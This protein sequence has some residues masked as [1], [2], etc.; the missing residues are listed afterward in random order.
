MTQ[1]RDSGIIVLFTRHPVAANL[2]MLMMILSGLWAVGRINT[3]L[4]PSVAFPGVFIDIR[5]PGAPAE[6]VEQLIVN[7]AEQQLSTLA[8]LQQMTSITREGGS[9]IRLELPFNSD[10]SAALD[11]V[12]DRLSQIRNFP[13]DMEPMVAR[14]AVDY[15]YIA[16]VLIVGGSSLAELV[17]LARRAERELYAAG[18]DRVDFTGLPEDELAIQVGSASLMAMHTTLD[19]LAAEIRQ[20]SA[21]VPAG[22]VAR[23][24]GGMQLRGMD[25]RRDLYQF[26]QLDIQIPGTGELTRLGNIAHIDRRAKVGQPQL[27]REGRPAIELNLRRATNSD[28]LISARI[29]QGWLATAHAQLPPGVEIEVYEEVGKLLSQQLSVIAKNASSGL[30]LVVF[31]LFLFLN[32]R[33]GWWVAVGIPVGLLFGMVFY[34]YLFNGSIN[35][36]ALITFIMAIGIVVDDT[37]VVGEDAVSLFEQGLSPEDAVS[38]AAQRMFMPVLTASLTTLAAFVPLLITGGEVGA[39]IQTMPMVLFCVIAASLVECFLVLP[40]HLKHSFNRM[41]R[42]HK[43]K[44]RAQVDRAFFGFRDRYYRPLLELALARPGAT[45]LTA[46][47]LTVLS[48][49]L[50]LSGRVG[51]NFVTGMSLQMLEANVAFT[52]DAP[53][54]ERERYMRHLELTLRDTDQQLGGGNLSG[55]YTRLNTARLSEENKRGLQYGSMKVEYAWEDVYSVSPQEF[56]TVWRDKLQPSPWVEQVVVEVRG[57]ENGGAPSLS[58]VLRGDGIESLKQASEELQQVLMSYEGVTNVI[59]SLPYGSDQ[60]VFNLTAEGKSLGI[61]TASLG[62]Q[63]RAAYYG[64]RVQILNQ[65]Q[66]E[67]EVSL[68]LPDAERDDIV[69]LNQFPVRTPRGDIVPLR[70]VADLSTRRGIDIINHTNG[71]PSVMVSAWVD[72]R[73]NNAERILADVRNGPL[74]QINQRYGLSAGLGGVSQ[75]NQQLMASLQTGALLTLVF[76]YLILAWSFSSYLWPLAVMAAIPLGMTGALVGHWVMDVELGIM[77]LLSFFALAGVITNNSI[78]LVSFLRRELEAGATLKDAIRNAAL[79]RFRAVLLTSLTTVAGLSPLMFEKFSLAIYMVPVAITLCF[80]LAVG[81][82]LVLVVIPSLI[83]LIERVTAIAAVIISKILTT[84]ARA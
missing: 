32:A 11:E 54:E 41:D 20:R 49:S 31:T 4:D 56:V 23:S 33:T 5:W 19:S 28:A 26:E 63:L 44:L 69:S 45:L 77:S 50:V 8:D 76:I 73:V 13:P 2:L 57:G 67:L 61:T 22:I 15:E 53:T 42:G 40:N 29:L 30:I 34:Y 55:Y 71:D 68:M 81:T 24:Q 16:S 18:I 78:V 3:Q 10:I 65:N 74:P 62:Q 27:M 48:A 70:L 59:D 37:I 79:S 25:Q 36:L 60:M 35:I 75:L 83:I 82:L 39:V 51:I 21:D 46:I 52:L 14:R 9:T 84:K 66:T 43:P 6:D 80:G 17:P 47:G 64:S 1:T 72:S 12:Q 38:T 7:P 58:L